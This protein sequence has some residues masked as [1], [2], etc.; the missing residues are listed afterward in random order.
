[1]DEAIVD[2]MEVDDEEYRTF[3]AGRDTRLFD[4]DDIIPEDWGNF[5]MD[6]L[7]INDGHES[8]WCTIKLRSK[9][10]NCSEVMVYK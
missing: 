4:N 6:G 2:K 1:M 7:T 5:D 10:D 8:N 9:A 3:V